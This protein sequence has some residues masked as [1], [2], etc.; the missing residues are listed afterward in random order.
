MA[1]VGSR[2]RQKDEGVCDGRREGKFEDGEWRAEINKRAGHIDRL[3]D[4]RFKDHTY[5]RTPL[6]FPNG[7]ARRDKSSQRESRRV[8][9]SGPSKARNAAD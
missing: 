5:I 9:F 7:P 2:Q 8:P 6:L 1:S 3:E 4:G